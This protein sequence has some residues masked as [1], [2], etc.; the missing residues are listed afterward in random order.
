[1]KKIFKYAMLFMATMT[2]ST[3]FI[4]CGDDDEEPTTKKDNK[5]NAE[6]MQAVATQYLNNVV[7]PTYKNLADATET[8]ATQLDNAKTAMK[9]G[10]LTDENLK[11]IGE[12]FL[13]ARAYWEA[14]EA[15]LYGP[16][17]TL[18]IDPHIDTW[19]L[20]VD[21]L[22]RGLSNTTMLSKIE[23]VGATDLA[24]TLLGFH[25]I[26]FVL[27]RDGQL[28]T[29][30]ELSG[31]ETDEAFSDINITGE[32]ELTYAA[33]VAEDLKEKCFQ[34]QVA[35]MGEKAGADRVQL[36][37]E[38]LELETTIVGDDY[39]GDNI[40]NAG[41]AG[42]SYR[43]WQDVM[44]AIL[45]AGC[46]NI[47]N[48]VANTKIGNAWNAQVYDYIESPYSKKSFIDFYNN[49]MS[50]KNSLYGGI[51]LNAPAEKSLLALVTAKNPTLATALQTKLDAALSA[52]Q[53][54]M[55]GKAFVDIVSE[56]QANT[57]TKGSYSN[58][59]NAIDA[60]NALDDELQA[61][62]KWAAEIE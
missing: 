52:V 54:C 60:I 29:V 42:S 48:E 34:L 5:E 26:E 33:A 51:G 56:L 23:E 9:A 46:S 10:Q 14:S 35:W 25:A 59:Q 20:D 8:L 11:T 22:A 57:A 58:V 18:G 38:E 19:P 16:A 24:P 55:N 45:N 1:M 4:A 12:T 32:Q 62:A 39:F 49:I 3:T 27:F 7:F 41:Q 30:A 36:V 31:K 17:T 37:E 6:A 21:A 61:G 28:R 15:F 13:S 44:V 50:I 47:C 43:S 53:T 40:L 2:L